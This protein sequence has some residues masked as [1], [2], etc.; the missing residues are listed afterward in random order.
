MHRTTGRNSKNKVEVMTMPVPELGHVVEVREFPWGTATFCDDYCR[1]K[2]KEEIDAILRSCA[3]IVV[4]AR[5][6]QAEAA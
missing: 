1:D 4:Q 6:R 5:L 3:E 2:T